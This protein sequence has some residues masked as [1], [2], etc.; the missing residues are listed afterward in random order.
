M[1][2]PCPVRQIVNTVRAK[3]ERRKEAR[4][5][6]LLDAAL[7]LF[8]EKGF[9]ATRVEEVARRAGVSKGTLFLY[10]SSKEELFKAVVRENISGRFAEWAEELKTYEG[11][12]EDLLR[13]CMT[14][15]WER[16]G[17]TRASGIPKLMMSDAGNFPELVAFFQQEVVQPGNA[18]IARILQRGVERGE[19]R[20][21]DPV[22]GVYSVLAPMMFLNLWKHGR[23]SC[24]DARIALDPQQYIASQLKTI[25][26]GL[27]ITPAASTSPPPSE[28]KKKTR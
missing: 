28:H 7:D 4:P 10:F 3:R 26:H 22:Y 11:S 12:S 15:W 27:S 5:G 14:S 21:V 18:L 8:L 9:A 20:A 13:Y 17:N 19:F 6:E 16:V 25:L 1:S 23:G 24:G 2:S